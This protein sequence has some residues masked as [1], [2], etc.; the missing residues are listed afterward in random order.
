[1]RTSPRLADSPPMA[2]LPPPQTWENPL[3]DSTDDPAVSTSSS[4]PGSSRELV[5]YGGIDP[6]LA[7]LDPSLSR[8]STSGSAAP[9]FQARFNSRTGRFQVRFALA[10][11]MEMRAGGLTWAARRG[12]PQ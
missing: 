9:A 2:D 3:T 1:M 11:W 10:Y 5:D 12:I 8:S 7:Y 6:E 4:A